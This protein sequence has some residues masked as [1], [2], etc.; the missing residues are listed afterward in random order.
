MSSATYA[1]AMSSPNYTSTGSANSGGGSRA[2]LN[3][4]IQLDALGQI[5]DS[6]SASSSY[7][8]QSGLVYALAD[9]LPPVTTASP[10]GAYYISPQSVTLSCNDFGGSGCLDIHFTIDGS[11]PNLLSSVYSSAIDI[12]VTTTLKYFAVDNDGNT[13]QVRQSIYLFEDTD[14][15]AGSVVIDAGSA[16]ANTTSVN[17][18]LSCS[19]PLSGCSQMKFSNDNASWSS[20]VTNA[21]SYGWSLDTGEGPKTVYAQ[22]KDVA[23]NWSGSYSDTIALAPYRITGKLINRLGLPIP[24]APVKAHMSGGATLEAAA[25]INGDFVIDYIR[26]GEYSITARLIGYR[27]APMYVTVSGADVDVEIKSEM[28]LWDQWFSERY[29]TDKTA[30][31]MPSGVSAIAVSSSEIEL[32]WTAPQD[33]IS[34]SGYRVFNGASAHIA[35]AVT[36]HYRVTGLGSGNEHCFRVSAFDGAGN[37]SAQSGQVCATTP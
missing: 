13:E 20:A 17:L 6:D 18:T 3:Y 7:S 16:F 35:T 11:E 24:Y 4:I 25:D 9:T 10:A 26:S 34:V 8:M 12:T 33:N 14:P 5:G 22:F 37:E 15:P 29:Y 21:S 32:K 36:D 28:S 30:P 31:G 23:G 1:V 19:D 27:F 2:S